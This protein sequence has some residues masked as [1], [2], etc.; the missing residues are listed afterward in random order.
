M[1]TL[2]K[3]IA[4]WI[5]LFHIA[6]PND[7]YQSIRVFDT[8][9]KTINIL[10]GL[11]IPLDHI[12][13]KE[14]VFIDLTVHED[15]T[16]ELLSQGVDLEILI[17]D[18]TVHY[19]SRSISSDNREFP[20]GSMQGNYTWDELNIRFDEL[21]S[22]YPGIISERVIIGQTIEERDIWAF[23]VSDNPNN[24]EN[25]PEVLYTALTHAREP[26]GMMNLFF[27]VQKIAEAYQTDPELTYLINN[28]EMWFIPVI[29]PDGYVYNESIQPDGG[30]MHRKNRLDTGCGDGTN[31]GVDINRNY[32]FGWGANN[33]GSSPN[34]CSTTY[35]GESEFSEPETQAVRDFILAREF[36][37]VLHYHTYSNIYIHA[38]G[39]GSLPEEPDLTTIVEIGEEMARYNGYVVGTGLSTIGYSVNGDAVDWTFGDQNII[40]YVPEVG[41]PSQGFWPSEN[42]VIELC[43]A[44]LYPNKIFAFVS[45]PD[46]ILHSYELSEE[47]I[48][49]SEEVEINL[50]VQNRGLTNSDSDIEISIS[51]LNNWTSLDSESYVLSEIDARD[52]DDFSFSFTISDDAVEGENS[53]IIIS[54]NSENGFSRID[55]LEFLIGQPEVLFFDG[56]EN[57]LDSWAVDGDWGLTNDAITGAFALSD[58]PEGDYQEAQETIAELSTTLNLNFLSNPIVKFSAKWDIEE[59]WDFVRFQA[60]VNGADWV[61]LKGIFTEPGSGQPAQPSGEQGYDGYQN[62]WV[63]E[64]ISLN[65]LNDDAVITGFRF[66]QTS[67]NYVEGDGFTVDDFSISGFP[68]GV[69]GDYNMDLV[70]DIFDL[71]ALADVILFGGQPTDAQLFFCDLDGSGIIDVMDIINLSN[72]IL[73][74]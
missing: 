40:S 32:G 39:N 35:R 54:I 72:M 3:F 28:R 24:D 44:Q 4:G 63:Q 29:N 7:V 1:R 42:E 53:G 6:F 46:I 55:T 69:M 8:T 62:L 47:F 51:S 27:F 36:K 74:F 71:L 48:M 12:T 11:G 25:E 73:G 49:P 66:I 52:S 65:Q 16:F 31:R 56:F 23:K 30:G 33:T 45:G 61:T 38:F 18:L 15:E 10:G 17:P 67:D 57:G 43:A 50:V 70:A 59:N 2:F 26:L 5:F 37:N 22:Q 68:K 19:K 58:S 64:A 13:G 41:S 34:P 14:G 20:L 9:T 60:N 21:Q